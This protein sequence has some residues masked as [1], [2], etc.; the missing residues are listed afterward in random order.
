M[1]MCVHNRLTAVLLPLQ[2]HCCCGCLR[3]LNCSTKR[4]PNWQP[5]TNTHTHTHTLSNTQADTALGL[6][7]CVCRVFSVLFCPCC[8]LMMARKFSNLREHF[9]S[10]LFRAAATESVSTKVER[11]RESCKCCAC[12]CVCCCMLCPAP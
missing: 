9:R 1:C 5:N 8:L 7:E 2:C 6:Y 11:R 12:M 10:I 3:H 4:S